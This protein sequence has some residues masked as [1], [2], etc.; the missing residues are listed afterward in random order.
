ML[1]CDIRFA[2][3]SSAS[4]WPALAHV[5]LSPWAAPAGC[6]LAL[7]LALGARVGSGPRVRRTLLCGSFATTAA[8]LAAVEAG[9]AWPLD[10]WSV[11]VSRIQRGAAAAGSSH[12]HDPTLCL[13]N[14]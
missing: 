8:T 14:P 12:L 9:V 10:R 6:A 5:M 11:R 7:L 1:R 3:F 2:E 4:P 13:I